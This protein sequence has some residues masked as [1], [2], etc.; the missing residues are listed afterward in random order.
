ML[1]S[2]S[3]KALET[4][5]ANSKEALDAYEDVKAGNVKSLYELFGRL[6]A[7]SFIAIR[8]KVRVE[9]VIKNL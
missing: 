4:F 8:A 3:T 2:D 6:E 9:D 1:D 7:I 5:F